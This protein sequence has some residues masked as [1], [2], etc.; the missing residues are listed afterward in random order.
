MKK[1]M[2]YFLVLV[3]ILGLAV[4]CS[5]KKEEPAPQDD[6]NTAE[7]PQE[8]AKQEYKWRL[9]QSKASQHPVSQG[10][11]KFAEIVAEKSD[12]RITIDVF[13]DA[14]LGSDRE[15]IES[16]QNGTLEFAGS[17]TPNMSSFTN[18]FTA[19]D[20]PYIF[21]NK[22]EVYK[23]IDGEP[24]T[25]AA[26][27]MEKAG[28]KVI[29]FPDYGFRQ[30]VNNV[31]EVKLPA[32][33][34]GLKVRTTNSP[35]EIADYKAFGANPTPIAWGEVYTALQQ[36]TVQGEGN[37]YSLLWDT[38][39]QEVLKYATEIN[40]NYSA[41]ILVMNKDLFDSLDPADQTLLMEA[42]KEAVA[43]QRNRANERE[44][45]AE[46]QFLDFGIKIYEPTA[47]EMQEWKKTVKP[48]WDEFLAPG[49][50]EPEYVDLI[51]ET[52]GKTKEDI[53]GN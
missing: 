29:F 40:Y 50:A 18:L 53:F 15:C 32:D 22:D 25:L 13:N 12:G 47:A 10:Y 26:K 3:L 49:K 52:I 39:H 30:V 7:Q 48:V 1:F 44:A 11:N 16:A 4:G 42:G 46:K 24:G 19:W 23:A 28:F 31:K 20:L 37:S 43:W 9:A 41:D 34:D 33:L 38:K 51:L 36:G 45:E 8:P 27:E 17:S 21:E 6:G 35:V 14:V 5:G 2:L